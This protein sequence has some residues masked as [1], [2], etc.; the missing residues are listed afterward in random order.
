[1]ENSRNSAWLFYA[2]KVKNY[3]SQGTGGGI[4]LSPSKEET[5]GTQ[6]FADQ[7]WGKMPVEMVVTQLSIL[8]WGLSV[9]SHST[10]TRMYVY[11]QLSPTMYI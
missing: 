7:G 5:K 11:I 8:Y 4:Q 3:I 1:M 6:P 10:H 2:R 9:H